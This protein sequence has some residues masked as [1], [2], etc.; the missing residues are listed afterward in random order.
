M[1]KMY[2]NLIVLFLLLTGLT[3]FAQDYAKVDATVRGYPDSFSSLD[4]FAEKVNAG[5]SR[6]DEKAWA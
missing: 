1:K 4:K 6:D 3:A 5:F 2:N